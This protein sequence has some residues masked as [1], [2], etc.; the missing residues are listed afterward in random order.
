MELNA[1]AIS[2]RLWVGGEPPFDRDIP[3]FDALV[4]CAKEIQPERTGFHGVVIRCP[5][6][7]GTVDQSM[8]AR[9]SATSRMVVTFLAGGKRVLI[10]CAMGLNRSAL[11][12]ALAIAQL[13]TKSADEIIALIRDKRDPRALYNPN[14]VALL[15]HIVGSGR[16]SER[17]T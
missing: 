15:H 9:V 5:I 8:L 7:D 4:L 10:T 17:W 6:V 13:T 3:G 14:F 2:N 16:K 12:A 11:V 1:S